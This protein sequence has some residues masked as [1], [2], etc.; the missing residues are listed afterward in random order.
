MLPKILYGSYQR[1]EGTEEAKR[2]RDEDQRKVT[3]CSACLTA[4]CWHGAFYCDDYKT[5][6][7]V[8]KTVAELRALDL[9]HPTYWTL[10]ETE[11][12]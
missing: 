2:L 6:G 9:E 5:A 1:S 7:T 10:D 3:V 4:S 11:G 8:E 12:R